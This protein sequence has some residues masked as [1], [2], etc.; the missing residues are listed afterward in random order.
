MLKTNGIPLKDIEQFRG[1]KHK[2]HGYQYPWEY[3][4][5]NLALTKHKREQSQEGKV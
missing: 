4:E 5:L 2:E 1:L 3:S